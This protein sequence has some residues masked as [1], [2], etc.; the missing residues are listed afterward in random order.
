MRKDTNRTFYFVETDNGNVKVASDFAPVWQQNFTSIAEAVEA[1]KLR[2]KNAVRF[3]NIQN[4][5]VAVYV[6]TPGV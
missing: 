5:L 3:D 6:T 4:G 2:N 1:V